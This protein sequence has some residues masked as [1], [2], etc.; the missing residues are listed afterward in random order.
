MGEAVGYVRKCKTCGYEFF[1]SEFERSTE[2]C[3]KCDDKGKRLKLIN[4]PLNIY[5]IKKRA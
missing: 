4:Q 5:S 3:K 1:Q 2:V